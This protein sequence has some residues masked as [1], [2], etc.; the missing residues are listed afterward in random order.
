MKRRAFIAALSALTYVEGHTAESVV[1]VQVEFS[2]LSQ[3]QM[4]N[5]AQILRNRFSEFVASATQ[6]V[7]ATVRGSMVTVV[8]TGA[9]L[10]EGEC[11]KLA[12]TQ[13]VWTVALQGEPAVPWVADSD[14]ESAH[15]VRT[16]NGVFIGVR[17]SAS[18]AGRLTQNTGRNIGRT[19]VVTWDGATIMSAAIRGVFGQEFNFNAP[20][21]RDALLMSVILRYGR[22]PA[23]P[24]S[25]TVQNGA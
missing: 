23:A 14:I 22:L 21:G 13:G 6:A 12:L 16:S 10:S 11:R 5:A 9:Q 8:S 15:A 17:V 2:G 19:L 3:A 4:A 18:A 7:E 24:K 25:A 20:P 1:R